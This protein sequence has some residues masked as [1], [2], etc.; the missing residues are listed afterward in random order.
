MPRRFLSSLVVPWLLALAVPAHAGDYGLVTDDAFLRA[1]VREPVFAL[2][3]GLVEADSLGT[4]TRRDVEAFAAGWGRPSDFPLEHLVAI[5]REALVPEEQVERRG[6]RCTRLITIELTAPRLE[7]PM[8]YSILGYHPGT[9]GFGSPLAIR[10]W[11]L[12]DVELHVRA[13]EGSRRETVHGFTIFQVVSGWAVLDVD[14]WLDNL[15]GKNLDD[16]ATLTFSAARAGGRIVGVGTSVGR[17]G[18]SIYGELDF[19]RGTVANHGR[20]LAR[21]LS[22]AARAF[23]VPDSGDRLEAWRGFG[24][25]E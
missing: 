19:R 11:H 2:V 21:A 13:D 25:T 16:S 8:P 17:E 23:A 10:E 5:R 4:W 22:G 6:L 12:G 18:R 24:D 15:L 1:Q 9:L 14:A 20:P 7:M 3:F